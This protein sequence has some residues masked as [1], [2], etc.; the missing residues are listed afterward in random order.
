MIDAERAAHFERDFGRRVGARGLLLAAACLGGVL[1]GG[2][3]Y[4][5]VVDA[6][7]LGADK[8]QVEEPYQESGDLDR[9]I[10]GD[11]PSTKQNARRK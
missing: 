2:C 6:R 3:T 4:S 5:R 1:A 7:G 8:V 11:E 10:F 9:W